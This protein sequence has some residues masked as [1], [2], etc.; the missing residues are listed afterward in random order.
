MVSLKNHVSLLSSQRMLDQ[1]VYLLLLKDL[2]RLRFSVWIMEMDLALSHMYLK[3]LVSPQRSCL[4]VVP[5]S[6][7]K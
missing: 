1:V 4:A 3:N 2:A 6:S 7:F 5:V